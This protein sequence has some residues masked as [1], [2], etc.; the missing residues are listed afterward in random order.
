M[1][2]VDKLGFI[3]DACSGEGEPPS[4]GFSRQESAVTPTATSTHRIAGEGLYEMPPST[5]FCFVLILYCLARTASS[6]LE[7]DQREIRFSIL[8]LVL[9]VTCGMFRLTLSFS[10][11]FYLLPV[12]Q[13]VIFLL[14]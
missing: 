2:I 8:L 14:N 9:W 6:R 5:M 1:S 7:T 12:V 10:L 3:F 4:F 13:L 11:N